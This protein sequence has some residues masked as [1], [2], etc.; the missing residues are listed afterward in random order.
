[1]FSRD[2]PVRPVS[3]R[4]SSSS[5]EMAVSTLI[6]KMR[7]RSC[8]AL[9]RHSPPLLLQR[10]LRGETIVYRNR[11]WHMY[12][13]ALRTCP[14]C[15]HLPE[16]RPAAQA[17]Q[18]RIG[19]QLPLCALIEGRRWG[20]VLYSGYDARWHGVVKVGSKP[21]AGIIWSAH[22][23]MCSYSEWG[24]HTRLQSSATTAIVPTRGCCACSRRAIGEAVGLGR[25]LELIKGRGPGFGVGEQPPKDV[26]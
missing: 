22:H 13:A 5:L 1:M 26:K 10:L 25:V 12:R 20:W 23:P 16:T 4:S 6:A 2:F 21:G 19:R 11:A 17:G 7:G 14:S 15:H 3:L 18:P 8:R 9:L 24:L